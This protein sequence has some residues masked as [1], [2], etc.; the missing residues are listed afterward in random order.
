MTDDQQTYDPFEDEWCTCGHPFAVHRD[1]GQSCAYV[2]PT[3]ETHCTC[4]QFEIDPDRWRRT[5]PEG[6]PP[7]TPAEALQSAV[8]RRG[9]LS[10]SAVIEVLEA[11][12]WELVWVGTQ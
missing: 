7:C 3:D 1:D 6:G 11:A 4:E 5:S 2:N 12:G 9:I 10:C 8:S